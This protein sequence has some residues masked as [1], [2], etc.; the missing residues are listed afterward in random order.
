MFLGFD[1]CDGVYFCDYLPKRERR[2]FKIGKD[3]K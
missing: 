1:F 2:E 3:S